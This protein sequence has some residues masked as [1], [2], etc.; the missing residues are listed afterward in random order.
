MN[1][2]KGLSVVIIIIL[3]S[4]LVRA[5]VQG[6]ARAR[7]N[8][9]ITTLDYNL[10]NSIGAIDNLL[11]LEKTPNKLGIC[12][13]IGNL[14][15]TTAALKSNIEGND[16]LK[17]EVQKTSI[18]STVAIL[19]S[20]VLDMQTFCGDAMDGDRVDKSKTGDMNFLGAEL[21]QI[22]PL[23]AEVLRFT[24]RLFTSN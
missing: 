17:S 19:N 2:L 24:N 20:K 6:P 15:V 23:A 1:F 8:A 3:G 10:S 22:K 11:A 21:N 18:Q 14:Y 4:A 13:E 16:D 12:K 5:D 9:G 7:V